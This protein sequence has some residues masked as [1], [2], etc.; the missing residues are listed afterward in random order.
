MSVLLPLFFEFL[1]HMHGWFR[2]N[3][4]VV[5]NGEDEVIMA[6]AITMC[7]A[8]L[9]LPSKVRRDYDASGGSTICP[10]FIQPIDLTIG[11]HL[12]YIFLSASGLRG[13]PDTGEITGASRQNSQSSNIPTRLKMAANGHAEDYDELLDFAYSLAEQVTWDSATLRTQI[14][15]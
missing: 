2:F 15:N 10:D 13:Y 12:R 6:T 7:K 3:I 8:T 4:A 9:Y 1:P 11:L 5:T 14:L